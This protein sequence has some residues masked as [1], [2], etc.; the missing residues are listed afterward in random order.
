MTTRS[1]PARTSRRVPLLRTSSALVV[2]LLLSLFGVAPVA[3][4]D[5]SPVGSLARPSTVAGTVSKITGPILDLSL[6]HI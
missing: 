3:A 6:I 4:A 2:A 5:G 1:L